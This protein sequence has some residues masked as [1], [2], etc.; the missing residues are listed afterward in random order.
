MNLIYSKKFLPLVWAIAGG[1]ILT[2]ILYL[3]QAAGMQSWTGP[4]SFFKSKWYF[5][6]PLILGFAVQ[7]WLWRKIKYF[8]EKH[9]GL[10]AASGGVSGSAMLACCLHNFTPIL[11]ILGI[12]ALATILAAYQD[13]IFSVSLFFVIFGLLY[14]YQK[15]LKAK[16]NYFF[17]ANGVVCH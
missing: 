6:L 5:I 16:R 9:L 8:H 2:L 12:N 11:G 4:I 7:V 15:Y 10:V 1:L 17:L 13:Y 14:L 3:I